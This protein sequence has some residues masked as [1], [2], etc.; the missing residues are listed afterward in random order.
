MQLRIQL[1][2]RTTH[3]AHA[4]WPS[5]AGGYCLRQHS[6]AG[7]IYLNNFQFSVFSKLTQNICDYESCQPQEAFIRQL[8]KI[9]L[10]ERSKKYVGVNF[11]I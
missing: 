5:V 3:I 10:M 11:T 7:F 6:S 9:F 1:L 4:W 2:S 8:K